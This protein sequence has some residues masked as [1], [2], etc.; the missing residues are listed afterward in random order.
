MPSTPPRGKLILTLVAA[1]LGWMFDGMEMG[2]F[3]IVAGPALEE[4][5]GGLHGAE[6]KTFVSGWMG[7][8]T[9]LFL[10]GAALGGI[11]FG[12][13]GDK[14]G[15]VRAMSLSILCYSLFTG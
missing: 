13:L 10:W 8:T 14:V 9:A 4:M 11:V 12:W 7:W 3:P 6:L 2:I 15:R 1:F 5:S